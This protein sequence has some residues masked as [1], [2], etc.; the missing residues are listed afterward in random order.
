MSKKNICIKEGNRNYNNIFFI[1]ETN[2]FQGYS[3]ESALDV[4]KNWHYLWKCFTPLFTKSWLSADS[5]IHFI[6]NIR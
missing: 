6:N 2:F 1:Y 3:S 5:H 4:Y